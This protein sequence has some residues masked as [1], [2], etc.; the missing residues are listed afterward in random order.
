MWTALVCFFFFFSSRRRHTRLQGD[1]SSDVCS[2]DLVANIRGVRDPR[3]GDTV[4]D[5]EHRD[6]PLLPGYRDIMSMVFAGL[7]PTNAEQFEELRDALAKLQL[8]DGSLH[9]EPESSV[10]LGF[11]FRCGF[12]GLLHM[13]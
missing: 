2:S 12:L 4:L 8:N 7:Y 5:A 13:E 6:A 3:P 1:W 10:A 11:G 9:Y